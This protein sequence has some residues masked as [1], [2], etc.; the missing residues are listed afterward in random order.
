MQ[1]VV[2]LAGIVEDSRVLP[3]RTFH[4]VFEGF[5]FEFGSLD[6]VVAVGQ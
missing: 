2:A 4:D 5:A 6:G 3:E 1:M